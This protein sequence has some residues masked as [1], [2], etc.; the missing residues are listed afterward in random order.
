MPNFLN[1]NYVPLHCHSDFSKFDGLAKLAK[2]VLKARL[3]GFPALA[4][5]DHGTVGG[6]V[7]FIAECGRKKTKKGE[8]LLIPG[9]DKPLPPLKAIV[10]A[11]FY[12]ARR[13]GWHGVEAER[14]GNPYFD[15]TNKQP[16][17][18]KGNRH[19][20]L[21]ARDWEGYQNLCRLSEASWVHGFYHNPRIDIELL[22]K[23]SKGLICQSACLSSL[24]N[25]LLLTDRF[26][27]AKRAATIFKDI[28][29]PYFFLEVMYHGISAEAFIIPEVLKLGAMLGIPVICTN[30]SHYI[31]KSQA[32]SQEVLMALNT[33]KCM[34]DPKHIHFP[35]DE[36]YLK[37]AQEMAVMFGHRPELL[38]NTIAVA[39]MVN[40]KEIET[41]MGGMRLPAFR[42]P[43]EFKD[44]QDYLEK[45]AWDG[46]KRLNWDTSE[47][48][49]NALKRELY[50][51]R[52]AKESNNYDFATY[53]L[54][55]WDYVAE[56]RKRQILTG[57]GRGSGYASVLLRA[58]NITYGPDPLVYGLLWERFLAFDD[59]RFVIDGDFGLD[60]PEAGLDLTAMADAV[61][62]KEEELAELEVD[63]EF[64][65]DPG[66]VDRY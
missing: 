38:H 42:V 46:M 59:K 10:G 21:L 22:A 66:G 39:E 55:V 60:L 64:E 37:S 33:S 40:A 12:L 58:L 63:R 23:H 57:C 3:M 28:F 44:P 9:T 35:Y 18:R 36:F 27:Q 13:H 7:K 61:E 41:K 48:H 43:P 49:V 62:E 1:S 56:A 8:P 50:D 47:R 6:W 14:E 5:T 2:F 26:D 29:G 34:L 65:E 11:E 30:D 25:H 54:V 52:V 16:D 45:L 53:F 19:L 32:R 31:E 15:G 20:I 24:I 51:V 17:G 4:L